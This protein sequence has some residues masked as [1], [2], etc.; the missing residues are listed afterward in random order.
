MTKEEMINIEEMT[1]TQDKLWKY[2]NNMLY[3]NFAPDNEAGLTRFLND[4]A[5]K[6]KFS[7]TD[8]EFLFVA[9]LLI[10]G[11]D[12]ES[13]EDDDMEEIPYVNIEEDAE[14]LAEEYGL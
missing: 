1:F 3:A 7:E 5:I 11:L 2:A 14:E 6:K 4:P 9:W 12:E 10:T 13:Y 8:R